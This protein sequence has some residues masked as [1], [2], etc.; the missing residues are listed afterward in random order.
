MKLTWPNHFLERLLAATTN[1]SY[2]YEKSTFA[3]DKSK[4]SDYFETTMSPIYFG[5][6]SEI[7][8]QTK[9]VRLD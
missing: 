7:L 3:S 6:R 9:W 2:K 1:I 5:F 4:K 8:K